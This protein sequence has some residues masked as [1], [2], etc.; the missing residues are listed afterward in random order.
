MSAQVDFTKNTQNQK[1]GVKLSKEQ[2]LQQTSNSVEKAPAVRTSYEHKMLRSIIWDVQFNYDLSEGTGGQAG[3]ETDGGYIYTTKWASDTI[4]RYK[5]NGTLQDTFIISGVTGLRDLAF[6]GTY[7]Y[8]GNA[9]NN[10]Y[11]LDFTPGAETLVSTITAPAG[12]GV[13]PIVKQNT[14]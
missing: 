10:I 6:D 14:L 2:V 4:F 11:Q 13:I 8:G 5:M 12:V 7:F 3:I 9:S 1:K